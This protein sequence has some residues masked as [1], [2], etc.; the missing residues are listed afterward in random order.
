MAKTL[1]LKLV[2]EGVETVGQLALLT[3]LGC[4]AYQGFYFSPAIPEKDYLAMLLQAT[5]GNTTGLRV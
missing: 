4:E 1:G 2:A 3:E 5:S